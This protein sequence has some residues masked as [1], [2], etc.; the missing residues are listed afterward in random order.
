[1]FKDPWGHEWTIATRVEDV[2][3]DEMERRMAAMQQG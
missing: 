1:M 3:E 2:P